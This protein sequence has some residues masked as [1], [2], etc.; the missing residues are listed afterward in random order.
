[1]NT[2]KP[3][4][5]VPVPR[6]REI[7][8]RTILNRTS[9]S[10]YSLNCYTGCEHGCVYCYARFMDRFH[11]HAEPWGQ[12]VDV[13]VNAVDAIL[14]QIRRCAPGSVFV[15]SACDAWQPLER[16]YRLTRR[17][18]EILLQYRF[19]VNVLTKSALVLDDLELLASGDASVGVTLTTLDESLRAL[20]EPRAARVADRLAVLRRAA[21]LGIET[22]VMFGPLLPFLSDSPASIAAL[23]ECAADARVGTIWFD[24]LNPR[25]RVWP[26]VASLLRQHYPDLQGQYSK[27]LFSPH[28]R[29]EYLNALRRRIENVA[30]RFRLVDRLFVCF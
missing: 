11:P 22:S 10:D 30:K 26:A 21:A 6:V 17:C 28:E 27:I 19:R 25:P 12:Y 7:L 18:C 20:W 8:C 3:L 5:T 15:S 24:A 14:R 13:K 4:A 29:A 2:H 1:M 9:I 16:R 23:V